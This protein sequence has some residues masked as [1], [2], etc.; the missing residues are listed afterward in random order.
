MQ[1]HRVTSG[2]A[3]PKDSGQVLIAVA[4]LSVVLVGFLGIAID[5]G[6][7]Y[8]LRR[9][10]QTAADAGAYAGTLEIWQT[11]LTSIT[12]AARNDAAI[13]GYTHGVASTDVTVNNPPLSGP[14]AGNNQFVEVI[15]TRPYQPFF[16]QV[17]GFGF[18]DVRARAVGGILGVGM[19]CIHAL[20]PDTN[21]ALHI[22]GGAIVDASDCAVAVNSNDPNALQCVGGSSLTADSTNVTGGVQ[23][24]SGCVNP[25][26]TT[27]APP[28]PD[29]LAGMATPFF[30][31]AGCTP[32]P[33]SNPSGGTQTLSPGVYCGGISLTG[34]TTTFAPGLYILAGGGLSVSSD[35]VVFGNGVTFFNTEVALPSPCG[36]PCVSYGNYNFT[37]QTWGRLAAPTSGQWAGLLMI[38]DPNMNPAHVGE[39]FFAGG[40]D[41]I[42][43]GIIY[44]P[45]SRITWSGGSNAAG[46]SSIIANEIKFTGNSTFNSDWS[47]F[48]SGGPLFKPRLV[49]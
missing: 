38:Q 32:S 2:G 12:T 37:G 16:M 17:L 39:S 35:A 25:A 11:R 5:G 26:A 13:N 21:A 1:D 48:G 44:M 43:E 10:A 6:Y 24:G 23:G 41:M 30:T 8:L 49:E 42:L 18:S 4:L 22:S 3:W 28:L 29:P 34:G 47:S 20:D 40:S 33:P 7:M 36:N 9:R 27:G 15:I 14:W 31:T 45:D 19:P 46:Y